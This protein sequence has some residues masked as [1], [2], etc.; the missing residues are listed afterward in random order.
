MSPIASQTDGLIFLWT[1]MG[2]RI[3]FN[4]KFF[5]FFFHGQRRAL[6]LVI[7]NVEDIVIFRGLFLQYRNVPFVEKPRL[8]FNIFENYKH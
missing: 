3:V 7:N 1:L 8:K 2:G 5:L 4:S 6:Y